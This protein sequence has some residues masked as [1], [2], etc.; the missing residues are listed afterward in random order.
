MVEENN[1]QLRELDKIWE[2][3]REKYVKAE[4]ER[5]E[6]EL[7]DQLNELSYV[8]GVKKGEKVNDLSIVKILL[9]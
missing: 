5:K 4:I 8:S 7:N 9:K 1:N 3:F 2:S 6:N